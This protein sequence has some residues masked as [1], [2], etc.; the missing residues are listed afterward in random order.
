M[1]ALLAG[2]LRSSVGSATGIGS[3]TGSATG[4]GDFDFLTAQSG[5][6]SLLGVSPA[7]V[8]RLREEHHIYMTADGRMNVAGITPR[9]VGYLAAAITAVLKLGI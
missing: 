3:G 4:S 7:A 5:M 1:R 6:F 8:R 2:A 9:N